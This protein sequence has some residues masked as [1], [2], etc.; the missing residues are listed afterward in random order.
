MVACTTAMNCLIIVR[1][2]AVGKVEGAIGTLLTNAPNDVLAGRRLAPRSAIVM[3]GCWRK[4][5]GSMAASFSHLLCGCHDSDG[6]RPAGAGSH[7]PR[8]TLAQ[9]ASISCRQLVIRI[10]AASTG[11]HTHR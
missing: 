3:L 4:K 10:G 8:Q 11:S 7:A 5:A 9:L 1:I 2:A 6:I